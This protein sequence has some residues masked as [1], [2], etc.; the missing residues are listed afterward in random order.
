MSSLHWVIHM[1]LK[2][3]VLLTKYITIFQAVA[4]PEAAAKKKIKKHLSKKDAKK[5]Q[6]ERFKPSKKSKKRR[7]EEFTVT[8][9]D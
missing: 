4:D 7:Y 8:D 1:N 6:Q 9:Q 2:S 3:F 5:R